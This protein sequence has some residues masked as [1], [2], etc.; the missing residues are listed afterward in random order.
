MTNCAVLPTTSEKPLLAPVV[1]ETNTAKSTVSLVYQAVSIVGSWDC[2]LGG[3]ARDAPWW[4][5]GG[6]LKSFP[7]SAG[8][9]VTNEWLFPEFRELFLA[10]AR[11]EESG[12][13]HGAVST[14]SIL[15]VEEPTTRLMLA[16]A[17][18]V[19]IA[20][21][22]GAVAD[23]RALG[24]AWLQSLVHQ[25]HSDA[26]AQGWFEVEVNDSLWSAVSSVRGR[27]P[28][29]ARII[30]ATLRGESCVALCRNW[31]AIMSGLLVVETPALTPAVSVSST[32]KSFRSERVIP[33]E[34]GFGLQNAVA[35]RDVAAVLRLLQQKADPDGTSDGVPLLAV[36]AGVADS[37]EVVSA[38]LDFAASTELEL[39]EHPLCIAASKGF[40]TNVRALVRSPRAPPPCV[41]NEALVLAASAGA[42][43]ATA[44]ILDACVIDR[45]RGYQAALVLACCYG[46]ASVVRLL[47]Q[48]SA[49][50][51]DGNGACT[52]LWN[53]CA[54][55]RC[56]VAAI[57][58]HHRADVDACASG[59]ANSQPHQDLDAGA[60]SG[61]TV[62]SSSV[63][64]GFEDCVELLLQQN[65]APTS[66][67]M[68]EACR[69][70]DLNMVHL[71]LESSAPVEGQ[72][73]QTGPLH[74]AARSGRAE[75]CE[76]LVEFEAS[77][78]QLD[79]DGRT[80]VDVAVSFA[81]VSRVGT[82]PSARSLTAACSCA[83]L[84]MPL[85]AASL[86]CHGGFRR[87]D[88]T[89]KPWD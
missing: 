80:P 68:L 34:L 82:E 25:S 20:G 21:G 69:V 54:F 19:G 83:V 32:A 47:L 13:C 79:A 63:S 88:K 9:P 23:G 72:G 42:V 7:C 60:D 85:S 41:A 8:P 73:G 50:A 30:D 86:H 29:A 62:L 16:D 67:A 55:G 56:E 89:A 65:A 46:Q 35:Q 18:E 24:T 53:A 61:D 33:A 81:Q 49:D 26:V 51:N 6:M 57:L 75:I 22:H 44:M 38:L 31:D 39:E 43:E 4:S 2:W 28:H 78:E 87:L 74:L 17:G 37:L 58:L 66:R 40:S 64:G 14:F 71:L 3:D 52:P 77:V 59:Q 27:C 1:W 15:I 12:V 10:L 48:C 84:S 11:L 70:G 5:I 36:A 45:A 76:L